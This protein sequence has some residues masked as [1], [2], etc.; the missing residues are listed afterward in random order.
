[1]RRVQLEPAVVRQTAA[2]VLAVDNPLAAGGGGPA[3]WEPPVSGNHPWCAGGAARRRGRRVHVPGA[4][5][6]AGAHRQQPRPGQTE[7]TA[8]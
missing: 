7:E 4:V 1:V 6:P 5:P 2:A 3:V 8:G